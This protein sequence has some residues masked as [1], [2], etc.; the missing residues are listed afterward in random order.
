MWSLLRITNKTS[1]TMKTIILLLSSLFLVGNVFSQ[2]EIQLAVELSNTYSSS[3]FFR[4]SKGTYNSTRLAI[5][6]RFNTNKGNVTLYGMY[7]FSG[8]VQQQSMYILQSHLLGGGINY[9]ILN[10]EKRFSPFIEINASTEVITN[11]RGGFL[12]IGDL[13]P[14]DY[15][16]FWEKDGPPSQYYSAFYY[17]TP[18]VGNILLGC[19]VRLVD[20]LHLNVGAGYGLRGMKTREIYWDEGTEPSE[21]L[22]NVDPKFTKWFNMIDIKLGISYAFSFKK[23]Q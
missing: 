22:R 23:K 14:T 7:E 15:G 13:F 21:E 10:K 1:E 6:S 19:D 2:K 18:F 8:F 9:R 16:G 17:S 3:R 5:G 20:G 12:D 4:F 11:Y